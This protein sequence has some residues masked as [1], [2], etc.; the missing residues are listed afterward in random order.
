MRIRPH[1]HSILLLVLALGLIA[2]EADGPPTGP[3]AS[4]PIVQ[5]DPDPPGADGSETGDLED[6]PGPPAAPEDD[7]APDE[8]P[9]PNDDPPATGDDQGEEGS[10]APAEDPPDAPPDGP[11][12]PDPSPPPDPGEEPEPAPEPDEP[13]DDLLAGLAEVLEGELARLNARIPEMV[14]LYLDLLLDLTSSLLGATGE[15]LACTP[16]PYAF[17]ADIVG[18]AGGTLTVGDHTLSIPAGALE[19]PVVIVG[20]SVPSLNV[21]MDL[22][23]DGL[24]FDKPV[25]L[26]LSYGHCGGGA[27][28]GSP[29]RIVYID[30]DGTLEDRP[31]TD[32]KVGRRV[33][34]WLDH[35]SRYAIA[36]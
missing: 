1:R 35:F 24:S 11:Q 13:D 7:P 25:A 3:I 34:G 6:D 15:L 21:E 9:A 22:A 16:L 31:S 12:D 28:D 30:E 20:Q 32:D 18:P 5:N 4:G 10:D 36:R 8:P 29:Y 23:P 14:V 19:E 17:D 2:C 26:T 33:T 27:G